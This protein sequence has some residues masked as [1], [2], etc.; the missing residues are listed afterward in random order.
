MGELGFILQGSKTVSLSL[1]CRS[2]TLIHKN[3]HMADPKH[4][5]SG[6][7]TMKAELFDIQKTEMFNVFLSVFTH[8]GFI[9]LAEPYFCCNTKK[10]Q[11]L[12]DSCMQE[13]IGGF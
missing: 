7:S 1:L 13:S 5:S 4:F 9:V 3:A 11:L 6:I 12:M 2:G 10:E 8:L